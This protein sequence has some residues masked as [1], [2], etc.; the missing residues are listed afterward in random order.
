MDLFGDTTRGEVT[1]GAKSRAKTVI[2]HWQEMAKNGI[3]REKGEFFGDIVNPLA[4][5]AHD[6]LWE[7]GDGDV[8]FKLLEQNI[9]NDPT[10]AKLAYHRDVQK[11]VPHALLDVANIVLMADAIGMHKDFIKAPDFIHKVED[12]KKLT[13]KHRDWNKKIEHTNI[14]SSSYYGTVI[15]VSKYFALQNIGQNTM[16]V[17]DRLL[18]SNEPYVGQK[19]NF[20]YEN[21]RVNIQVNQEHKNQLA[22]AR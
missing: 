9:I 8:V 2:E 6:S 11:Y 16:V 1:K 12:L 17:H 14:Q 19:A 18:L 13:T 3:R 5:R 20:K 15:D 7:M 21:G 10:I 22:I 4:T